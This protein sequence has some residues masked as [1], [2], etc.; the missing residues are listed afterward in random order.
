MRRLWR[1][2]II[3]AVVLG[4]LVLAARWYLT[5]PNVARQAAEQLAR[6]YGGRVRVAHADIGLRSS[7][8]S[9]VRLYEEGAP[10]GTPWL[11]V[12]SVHADVSLWDLI[13]GNGT[14]SRIEATGAKALLRFDSK[15]NLLTRF[16]SGGQGLG[17]G[18]PL[19]VVD[20]RQS[21]ITFRKEGGADVVL[22]DVD[23]VLHPEGGNL[24]LAGE[25]SNPNW[26][27]LTVGGQIDPKTGAASLE[28]KSAGAIHVT[29][30]MLSEL[31]FI[32]PT[33]WQ[34]VK[35][36]GDTPV[37]V[38]LR[39]DPAAKKVHYRVELEPKDTR[40]T[41][42]AADLEATK[43]AG[44]LIIEDG[45]VKLR[46]VKGTAYDGWLALDGDLD[47]RGQA[48]RLDFARLEARGVDVRR[49]PANWG[50]PKELEGKL[51]ASGTVDITLDKGKVTTDG[52]AKAEIRD[53]RL[54]GQAVDGPIQIQMAPEG[55]PLQVGSPPAP[56]GEK[57]DKPKTPP[58]PRKRGPTYL[59]IKLNLKDADVAQ[60]A[61]RLDL[62]LPFAVGGRLDFHGQAAIPLNSAR[63]ARTYRFSGFA[64][65]TNAQISD[66]R[67]ER[68]ETAARY[69]NGVLRLD[70]L[71]GVALDVPA[72][73]DRDEPGTLRGNLVAELVP[74]GDLTAELT[75]NRLPLQQAAEEPSLKKEPEGEITGSL[76]AKVSLARLEKDKQWD[77]S[78]KIIVKRAHAYGWALVDVGADVRFEGEQ[79]KLTNVHGSLE[80]ATITGSGHVQLKEPYPYKATL[81]LPDADLSSVHRLAEELRPAVQVSG[82]A[83]LHADL[84]GTLRPFL[85][86][87][88]GTAELTGLKVD[89]LRLQD[90]KF[91]WATDLERLTVK[92]LRTRLYGG[93]VSGGA[94][95]PLS[96]QAAGKVDLTLKDIDVGRLLKEADVDLPIE[97]RAGGTVKGTLP[98]A[99]PG[100]Q[101]PVDLTLDLKTPKLKVQGVDAE[102]LHGKVRYAGE[103]I[104]YDFGARA[105]GGTVEVEGKVPRKAPEP[106]E[107]AGAGKLRANGLH[108]ERLGPVFGVR[109]PDWP[110]SGGVDLAVEFRHQGPDRLPVGAGR[111]TLQDLAWDG[112]LW[113]GLA[114]AEVVLALDRLLVRDATA[115]LAGGSVRAGLS[116]SW[117]HP[118]LN[119][120]TLNVYQVDAAELLAAWPALKGRIQGQISGNARG[121]FGL[122][123][124]SYGALAVARGKVAGID[125]SD[126]RL[127]F[128]AVYLAKARRGRVDVQGASGTLARGRVTGEASYTWGG[129][130][131]LQGKLQFNNVELRGVLHE[132]AE[133]A[134]LGGGRITGQLD[135]S[136]PGLVGLDQLN[137][138]LEARLVQVQARQYPV[139]RQL[140][141]TL[142]LNSSSNF[143]SGQVRARLAGGVVR[144]ERL[145]L[146]GGPG[147]IYATG[148]VTT[149]GRL[150]LDVHTSARWV[151]VSANRLPLAPV[152]SIPAR[153]VGRLS[154]KLTR[155]LIHV[156]VTGTIRAPTV[157]IL[158]VRTIQEE[159]A[160]FFLGRA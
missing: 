32:S 129:A 60:M 93:D 92:D 19:P 55:P 107:E 20:L 90:A 101:R 35:A 120:Y 160:R 34:E 12:A 136:G 48:S 122:E 58:T 49:L 121:R 135:F 59:T 86:E 85:L 109:Q 72:P 144:V 64:A 51:E 119:H 7:T 70:K 41:V 81:H 156:R 87:S 116:L 8:L 123:V 53:A 88:S 29:Q 110:L 137:A 42:P 31:P 5:S 66:V 113:V 40:V 38:K 33:V 131:Q 21:Q 63:D 82:R 52:D 54:A 152:T 155:G 68:I 71:Y 89:E 4:I 147:D 143:E 16:P 79:L 26:G 2:L 96:A 134:Y 39:Y 158:P 126:W 61:Q 146:Q 103:D 75:L 99:P 140:L 73:A 150:G 154:N 159:V 102:G 83:T 148:T 24:V 117:K 15:G 95:V 133:S 3:V 105:L 132:A 142:G 80:G 114:Q 10:N 111:V 25:G 127:P 44:R 108:L 77:G 45:V 1:V 57:A 62:K 23:A 104:T 30:A 56:G 69:E 65:I 141:P 11:T 157:Q 145:S 149:Q 91:G 13:S 46:H 17:K 151:G 100:K 98:P 125:V 67:L 18:G 37:D 9:G 78:G 130:R 106:G 84:S 6:I 124:T 115:T 50:L 28:L 112:H 14:P 43:A 97:G 74:A 27:K 76:S 36:D 128:R 118:Q 22:N 94:V 153:A 138:Y 139:F 47:F